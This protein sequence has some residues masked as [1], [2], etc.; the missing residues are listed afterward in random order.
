M[1]KPARKQHGIRYIGQIIVISYAFCVVFICRVNQKSRY[2]ATNVLQLSIW[3]GGCCHKTHRHAVSVPPGGTQHRFVIAVTRAVFRAQG[4]GRAAHRFYVLGV[5]YIGQLANVSVI[6]R[7]RHPQP[8]PQVGRVCF[9]YAHHFG[10]GAVNTIQRYNF[11]LHNKNISK[12]PANRRGWSI[13][14]FK[15]NITFWTFFYKWHQAL[16]GGNG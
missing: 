13:L 2:H 12:N 8:R 16:P 3:A 7:E 15:F 11:S 4:E 5:G 14:F 10:G 1:L 6:H 9:C